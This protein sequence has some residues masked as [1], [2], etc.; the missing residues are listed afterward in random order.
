MKKGRGDKR[1]NR[2]KD[3]KKKIY[4]TDYLTDFFNDKKILFF[5]F[6]IKI[7][8]IKN[9][10]FLY[11]VSFLINMFTMI[12]YLMNTEITYHFITSAQFI[13]RNFNFIFQENNKISFYK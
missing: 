1:K 5:F 9:R 10:F 4:F 8:M 2:K 6:F 3:R 7:M 11:L 13:K 12:C